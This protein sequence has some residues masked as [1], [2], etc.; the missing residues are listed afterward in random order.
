MALYKEVR[1]DNGIT[2]N[3]HRIRN[4]QIETNVANWVEITSYLD[5]V[6]REKEIEYYS[7]DDDVTEWN[8]YTETSM[9]EMPYDQNM[10]VD[11]CYEKLKKMEKFNGCVDC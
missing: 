3:Y 4:I 6:A 1:L 11:S 5:K 7:D 10:T 8:G 2:L 9:L